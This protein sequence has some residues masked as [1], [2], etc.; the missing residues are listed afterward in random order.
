MV[1]ACHQMETMTRI[2]DAVCVLSWV[3]SCDCRSQFL[4]IRNRKTWW[5]L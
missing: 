2:G 4:L 1:G 5:R 3:V